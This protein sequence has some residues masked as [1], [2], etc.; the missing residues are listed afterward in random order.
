MAHIPYRLRR[1][2]VISAA[3]ALLALGG[4]APALA[5]VG[6]LPVPSPSTSLDPS[7]PTLPEPLQSTVDG[8]SKTLGLDS[9]TS[10]ST[11]KPKRH[12]RSTDSA[13]ALD[14]S[15]SRQAPASS[16]AAK[17]TRPRAATTPRFDARALASM[18]GL[19]AF[20]PS[21]LQPVTAEPPSVAPHSA[22]PTQATLAA[23]PLLPSPVDGR[24]LDPRH[25]MAILAGLLVAIVTTF[26]L[27]LAQIR[28]QGLLL[29]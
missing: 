12:R 10:N 7:L 28:M 27:R 19:R 1:P 9:V 20:P 6:P 29:G 17:S 3:T 11:S 16:P 4:A 25:I 13:P 23:T 18:P 15:L 2:A 21:V 24:G 26:H 8:V 22:A 5:D 14:L